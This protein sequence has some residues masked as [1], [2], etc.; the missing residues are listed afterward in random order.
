MRKRIDRQ[1]DGMYHIGG[2]A[3]EDLIGTRAKVLHGTAYKTSGGL[4]KRDIRVNNK[5]G[6]IVSKKRSDEAR[7]SRRLEKAG[8]KPKKGKFVLMRKT[9]KH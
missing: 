7:K 1:P 4:I 9:R 5:T 3:F 2:I 8:Y 6:R